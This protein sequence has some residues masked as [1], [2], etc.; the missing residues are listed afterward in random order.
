MTPAITAARKAKIAH[1]VL[2]YEHDPRDS[3]Y[4]LEAVKALGVDP[5]SVFKTLM[6]DSPTWR[7]FWYL[8]LRFAAGVATFT[9]AV[10]LIAVSLGLAFGP[11]FIWTSDDLEWF[12]WT[13]D[14]FPWSFALVPIGILLVFVSLH[15]MNAVGTACGRWARWSLGDRSMRSDESTEQI[16]VDLTTRAAPEDDVDQVEEKPVRN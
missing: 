12:G 14:P 15:I 13:I 16:R 11:T 1:E 3:D 4:G 10:T 6:A 7:G 8:F 5:D 2:R 9:I